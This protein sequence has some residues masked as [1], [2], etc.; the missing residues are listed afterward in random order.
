MWVFNENEKDTIEYLV[1]KKYKY[2]IL[3]TFI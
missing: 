2:A 3:F 1:A